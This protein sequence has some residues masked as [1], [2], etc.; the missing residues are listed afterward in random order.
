MS[1]ACPADPT[2]LS[3]ATSPLP[4][5]FTHVSYACAHLA[6]AAGMVTRGGLEVTGELEVF[7]E[8]ELTGPP[9]GGAEGVLLVHAAS[10]AT[11][12][13]A[14]TRAR[15]FIDTQFPFHVRRMSGRRTTPISRWILGA[16]PGGPTNANP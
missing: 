4:F 6:G 12:A 14:A 3:A 11:A 7:G 15:R 13:P 5:P 9:A 8:S 10:P 2:A 1:P 16:G